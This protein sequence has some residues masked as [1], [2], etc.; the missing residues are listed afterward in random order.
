LLQYEI[1]TP[2]S[3]LTQLVGESHAARAYLACR[4]AIDKLEAVV[5]RLDDPSGWTRCKSLYFASTRRHVGALKDEFDIRRKHGIALEWLD[6]QG[7]NAQF[8]LK[9][10][11]ALLSHDAAQVDA[12]RLTHSLLRAAAAKGLR[13]F[14]R[15]E[16]SHL[17]TDRSGVR[18]QTQRGF[19]VR[20][21]KLVFATGY[22]S[23][24]YLKHDV[25]KLISTFALVS[26]PVTQLSDALK[27]HL[28]WESARPYLYMRS[29]QDGRLIVGG[30]DERFRD[31]ARRDRLIGRKAQKLQKRVQMLFPEMP[32]EVAF[33]WAGTFGETKD[34][35]AYIGETPEWP[36]AYFALGYGGNGIT[37]SV[38]AAE[39]I[40]DAIL[41]RPNDYADLFCFDR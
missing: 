32:F 22:E 26:E 14:D 13:V 3:E 21:R 12:Y 31:P 8:G 2:L 9:Q 36:H 24:A 4:D 41:Q 19:S 34:G 10:P 30:E 18:V 33:A 7:L 40:R 29:T 17:K 11:A 16:A 25:A 28:I 37:Y 35:L 20:G 27:N 39:I 38:L 23:Q 6:E 1:D 5:Q 15:T